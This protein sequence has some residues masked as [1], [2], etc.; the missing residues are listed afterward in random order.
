[1]LYGMEHEETRDAAERLASTLRKRGQQEEAEA[2][3][4]KHS[5]ALQAR[6]GWQ[7]SNGPRST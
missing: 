5:K 2:L 7:L 3:A 4:H 6:V 1:M